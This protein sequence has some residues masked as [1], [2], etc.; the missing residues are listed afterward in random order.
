MRK[1]F[2]AAVWIA[3]ATIPAAIAAVMVFGCCVLPF[4]RAIHRVVNL[5]HFALPMLS[6][7][8]EHS[9]T[10]AQEKREPVKR[11]VSVAPLSFR[12]ASLATSSIRLTMSDAVLY[13]SFTTNGATRCDRD[14]GLHL[15]V[16]TFRI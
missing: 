16:N 14:I 11:L 13:R 1:T 10:P 3:G 7:E 12:L 6:S 4:H 5:C 2:I 8:S 9:T 15:L